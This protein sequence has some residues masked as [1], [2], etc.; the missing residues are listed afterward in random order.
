VEARTAFHPAP[1]PRNAEA[2]NQSGLGL[3]GAGNY[4]G[5]AQCFA[6]ALA[7]D[8]GFVA[9]FNNLSLVLVRTGQH[10]AALRLLVRALS[11][12]HDVLE[13]HLNCGGILFD[14][15]EWDQ[16]I[17]CYDRALSVDPNSPDA[18]VN[19]A[20]ALQLAGRL[21]EA[22]A[23][24]VRG[25]S[26]GP[27]HAVAHGGLGALDQGLGETARAIRRY[28]RTLAIAPGQVEYHSNLLFSLTYVDGLANE[29]LFSAFRGWEARHA[30]PLY[31]EAMPPSNSR[32]PDR[33]LRIGYLS[34]DFR[35]HP[36]AGNLVESLEQHDR[37]EVALSLYS[38]LDSSD[39]M[40]RRLQRT[41]DRWRSVQGRDERQIAAQVRDDAIDILVLVGSHTAN[42]RPLVAALKPAPVQVSLYD[43]T[44]TGMTMVDAWLTDPLIHPPHET[45]ELFTESLV[46]VPSLY[47]HLAPNPAPP[48][49][50]PPSSVKGYVTF[51]SFNNPA[52]ISESVIE[53]W[54]RVLRAVP[55]SRLLLKYLERYASA[56][57]SRS[58]ISGF[59]AHGI[60]G[61]R[62]DLR[63]GRVSRFDQLALLN[64][65]DIALDPFPFNGCTSTFEALWMGVPVVALDGTR[66]L[67]RM[68][69]SF[70][71]HA[72]LDELIAMDR[73]AY[74]TKAAD[75]A[76]DSVRRSIMRE[77]LR[78]RLRSSPLCDAK[79][80]ARSLVSAYRSLWRDWCAG[81]RPNGDAPV[82]RPVGPV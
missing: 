40:S 54:A 25:L 20:S 14:L 2:L 79:S 16:A 4:P 72:G 38:L 53:L 41:A 8:P 17:G 43:L 10:V 36:V 12:R 76:A 24:Y 47:V 74:V 77:G 67:G 23:G 57:L 65:V 80:H 37:A 22:R 78:G 81:P 61:H 51:G 48:V 55:G 46:R 42:H 44:T 19:R 11:V 49:A 56:E 5:A 71:R 6:R 13:T 62:L 75:L 63:A 59:A 31:P 27:D 21:D 45:T 1:D 60:E 52:K 82:A 50:P 26:I 73:R 9:A 15:A 29:D 30:V 64:E 32:D 18:H 33:R 58:V 68:S 39:D 3:L 28:R 35:E 69:S 7:L 34:A 66:F 70:L